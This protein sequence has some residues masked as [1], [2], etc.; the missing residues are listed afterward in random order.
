MWTHIHPDM[1]VAKDE[2]WIKLDNESQREG[3]IFLT[4]GKTE[5]RF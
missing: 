4:F 2:H 1:N 3:Q 5:T